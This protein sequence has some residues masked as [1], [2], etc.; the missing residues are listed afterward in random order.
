MKRCPK[1][2]NPWDDTKRYC[3]YHG[4]LLVP[5]PAESV[6]MSD[7]TT[8]GKMTD[9]ETRD[10]LSNPASDGRPLPANLFY[11]QSPEE[12]ARQ[13]QT[14]ALN[15]SSGNVRSFFEDETPTARSKRPKQWPP[16]ETATPTEGVPVVDTSREEDAKTSVRYNAD[17]V[18]GYVGEPLLPPPTPPKMPTMEGNA[19]GDEPVFLFDTDDDPPPQQPATPAYP[20]TQPDINVGKSTVQPGSTTAPPPD[21][22]LTPSSLPSLF[23]DFEEDAAPRLSQAE[24]FRLFNERKKIVQQF[25]DMLAGQGFLVGENY[26]NRDDC[27]LHQFDVGFRHQGGTF[28]FPITVM[29]KRKPIY[30]VLLSIDLYDIGQTPQLRQQRTDAIS[31]KAELTPNGTVYFLPCPERL[32]SDKLAEWLDVS[33]RTILKTGFGV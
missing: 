11:N 3:P 18:V 30:A 28:K 23:D 22:H 8:T 26:I 15:V 12:S 5:V 2:E 1:C 21:K 33:F 32:P 7:P 16:Q 31:G 25:V 27:I 29:L 13:H 17:T 6:A 14:D 19:F 9:T 20:A 4:L 10:V 24:Y